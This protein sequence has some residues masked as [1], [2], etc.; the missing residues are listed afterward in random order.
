MWR[1]RKKL[2][3]ISLLAISALGLGGG[4]I[5]RQ[6]VMRGYQ[7][8]AH[9]MMAYLSTLLEAYHIENNRYTGF[10]PYGAQQNGVDHCERPEPALQ[11]GFAIPWCEGERGARP[12]RYTYEVIGEKDHYVIKVK[13]GSDQ[14]GL[15]FVCLDPRGVDEWEK[16]KGEPKKHL[17]GCGF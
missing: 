16:S 10:Q 14:R 4:L 1:Y 6:M 7:A 3:A 13:S 17:S 11:L 2:I 5:Y 15:S 12:I 8:E 9:L